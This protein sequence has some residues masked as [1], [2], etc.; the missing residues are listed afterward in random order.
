[1]IVAVVVAIAAIAV[2][3][4][5]VILA[6]RRQQLLARRVA[7]V[8]GRLGES[9]PASLDA[10]EAIAR[11]S[12]AVD[13]VQRLDDDF[14][15]A[16]IRLERALDE[17]KSGIVVCDA[18]GA[19]V[20]RNAVALAFVDARHGEAL[21]E[22]AVHDL[23]TAA[24]RGHRGDRDLQIHGP[25]PR[26]LQV[27]AAPLLSGA[28]LVGAIAVIHDVTEQKR[29]D[30]VRRDFVANVSHE[31]KTPIGA[32]ALLAETLAD[33]HDAAVARRLS[34]RLRDE[35]FRVSHIVDDLL[36]LSRIEGDGSPM[37][38]RVVLSSV[39][40][41]AVARVAPVAERRAVD[42][43]VGEIDERIELLG[44]RSQ[45]T[46]ALFNLLDNAVKYSEPS[47]TIEVWIDETRQAIA[48]HVRDHGIGIPTRD[49]ER[50][51]ERFYR[52]DK[53]RS[54]DTGGTGLGLS[55]VRHV[56]QNHGGEVSVVSREGEGS[57]FTIMLP[58][59]RQA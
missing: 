54:R 45:L 37:T 24:L 13:R 34:E 47:S 38:E 31:L 15:L 6:A 19:V 7:E 40:D 50:V 20:A 55:I 41:E 36:A 29:I 53:A 11:L 27:R 14:R 18:L 28:E 30:A 9:V 23:I 39:V 16:D 4:V 43:D 51:F 57:T 26:S 17:V 59:R 21:V 42:I 32:L 46:S 33:E 10:D 22:A 3:G 1:V 49:L 56:V 48:L 12:R 5:A 52:V 35:S 58:R 8:V 2:A 44:D 25:P